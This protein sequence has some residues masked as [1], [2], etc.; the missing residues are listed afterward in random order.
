MN[1]QQNSSGQR[2]RRIN[3]KKMLQ[4]TLALIGVAVF[5]AVVFLI[6][7][8][9]LILKRPDVSEQEKRRLAEF[10]TFSFSSL[11]DGS[12]TQGIIRYFTDT[13]PYRDEI[14]D[15]GRDISEHAGFRLDDVKMHG[16]VEPP[17]PRPPETEPPVT[18]PPVTEPPV[19][20]PPV[21]GPLRADPLRADPPVRSRPSRPLPSR[22]S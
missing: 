16:V 1:E 4:R 19:T 10:P 21:T 17:V 11:W 9:M 12:Y 2:I 6:S 18:E 3:K 14:H 7:A 5:L 8:A 15:V 22:P 13:A 20:E